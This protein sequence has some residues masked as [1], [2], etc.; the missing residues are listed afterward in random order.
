MTLRIITLNDR[1][2]AQK[3]NTLHDSIPNLRKHKLIWNNRKEI[4]SCLG[5]GVQ[6]GE[7]CDKK[8]GRGRR[9]ST[10]GHTRKLLGLTYAHHLD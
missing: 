6:E 10:R 4:G 3:K 2:Q 8:G 9:E 7:K 1:S 5:C